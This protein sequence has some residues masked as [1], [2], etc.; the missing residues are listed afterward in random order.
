M[1]NEIITAKATPSERFTSMVE[2]QYTSEIG[3]LDMT[4]YDRTLLQHLFIKCDASFIEANA[5]LAQGKTPIAWQNINMTKLAIDAVNRIRLGIDALI[6]GHLYPIAYFNGTTKQ[7]DIDLRIGYKGEAY[8]IRQASMRPIRDI[9]IELVYSTDEF[10]VF[11]KGLSS[12]VEGYDFHVKHPFER[13]DVVGGFAYIEYE[14]EQDNVL[15]VLSKKSFDKYKALAGSDRFWGSW[16]EEMC[17]KTLVH[18]ATSRVTIDPRKINIEAL[19]TVKAEEE[20]ED[21]P[22]H[23]G[24]GI[25]LELDPDALEKPEQ[26]LEPIIQTEDEQQA[27]ESQEKPGKSKRD[28]GF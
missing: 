25:N 5:K 20:K 16:Y 12:K 19:A 9:R 15:I 8:Y 11:K 1:A 24:N 22:V 17:Y 18:R 28:P 6:P 14:D 3:K 27:E 23:I 26:T 7:Y 13:G 21:Q 10:I 4:D 2:R